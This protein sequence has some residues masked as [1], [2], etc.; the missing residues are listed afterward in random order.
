MTDA[1]PEEF[2]GATPH[3][4]VR[5]VELAVRFYRQ[6]FGADE[7]TRSSGPDG[8]VWHSE[9][10]LAGGRVML[11]EEFPDTGTISPETLGGTPVTLHLFVTDTDSTYQRA[12]EAGASAVMTP[13]DAFWGDRYAQIVDPA[14]HRWSMSTRN[15]D[16]SGADMADRGEQW[17]QEHSNPTSPGDVPGIMAQPDS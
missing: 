14:G 1:T 6:V 8:R 11:V 2:P 7:L 3:L 10:L 13:T 5:S 12:L 9:F 4:C 15:E 16:L 17:R